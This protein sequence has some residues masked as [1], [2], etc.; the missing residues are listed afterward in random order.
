[1]PM[2]KAK[3]VTKNERL[4]QDANKKYVTFAPGEVKDINLTAEMQEVYEDGE[5]LALGTKEVKAAEKEEAKE[6]KAQ[7]VAAQP[8]GEAV[9][10]K[11]GAQHRRR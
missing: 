11:G 5:M 4:V 7:E 3:N 8:G 1:M 2:V 9:A 10:H 6:E